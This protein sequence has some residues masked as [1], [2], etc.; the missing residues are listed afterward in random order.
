M[1]AQCLCGD[2]RADLPG[3]ADSVVACHCTDCQRRSGSPFGVIAYYPAHAVSLHGAARE[4][5][6]TAESGAGFTQAFCPRCGT[7]IWCR[8]DKHPDAIGIPVGTIADAGYPRP[9]RSV[10]EDRRHS[11]V[12]MPEDIAHF[13]RGRS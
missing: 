1:Q 9:V 4:Y 10:W 11:W 6:R 5:T 2:L 12:A 8:A 7:T 3:P 13:P